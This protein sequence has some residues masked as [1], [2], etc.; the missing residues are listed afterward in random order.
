[1]HCRFWWSLSVCRCW[2]LGPHSLH[3]ITNSLPFSQYVGLTPTFPAKII[4]LQFGQHIHHPLIAQAGTYMSH[5]IASSS[6][7][8]NTGSRAAAPVSCDLDCS[9]AT[10]CCAGFGCCR[11]KLVAAPNT[12]TNS[13]NTTSTTTTV[14][15]AAGG[16]VVVRQ[17]APLERITVDSRSVV[18]MEETVR[19]G[20]VPN[21]KFCMC[22]CGGEGC[23]STTLTGPGKVFL[24]VC[25]GLSCMH[26]CCSRVYF[27]LVHTETSP[28]SQLFSSLFVL[29]SMTFQKF[30]DAVQGKDTTCG[31]LLVDR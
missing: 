3:I 5:I 26:A 9:C 20:I 16:T 6:S 10:C 28:L 24:Q 1:M 12:D 23:C 15:L 17:L 19:L 27:V 2:L 13:T 29:Q 30:K 11:Q 31:S 18:A 25:A 8:G 7:S 21:G 4:P 14:F 22:C